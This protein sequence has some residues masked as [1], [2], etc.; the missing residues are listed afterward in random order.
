M[1]NPNSNLNNSHIPT[2]L[3]FQLNN[4]ISPVNANNTIKLDNNFTR[5]QNNTVMNN[6]K[7]TFFD[8]KISDDEY[9]ER[10]K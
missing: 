2:N 7:K 1:T 4:S 6:K 10:I 3:N 8:I 5:E 9:L